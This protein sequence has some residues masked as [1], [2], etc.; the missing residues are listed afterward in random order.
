MRFIK[1]LPVVEAY[2]YGFDRKPGWMVAS[3]AIFSTGEGAWLLIP[4][5]DGDLKAFLGDY[6]VKDAQ[7]NIYPMPADIFKATYEKVLES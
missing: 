3:E 2:Q 1:R 4:T 5:P 7:G 6:I